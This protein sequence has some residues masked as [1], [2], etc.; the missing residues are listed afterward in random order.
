MTTN[1]KKNIA[2]ILASAFLVLAV[3]NGWPYSFFTILRLVVCASTAYVAW[4]A[5]EGKRTKW[6]WAFGLLAVLFNPFVPFYLDRDSWLV[7]DLLTALFLIISLFVFKFSTPKINTSQPEKKA[8]L[9]Y[10]EILQVS[11][12]AE[13]EVVEV[14]YR[15]LA[16]KYHPDVN[17]SD[18]ASLIM[19]ELNLAYQVLSDPQ[20]RQ[21]YDNELQFHEDTTKASSTSKT[22][23]RWKPRYLILIAVIVIVGFAGVVIVTNLYANQGRASYSP[24]PTPLPS[25]SQHQIQPQQKTRCDPD[26]SWEMPGEHFGLNK[27]EAVC[28]YRSAKDIVFVSGLIRNN[29]SESLTPVLTVTVL[30]LQGNPVTAS[31]EVQLQRMSS[32]EVRAINE[33]VK[34]TRAGLLLD[35]APSTHHALVSVKSLP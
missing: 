28:G 19:K 1:K 24:S 20:S 5:Y 2:I 23:N 7:I 25:S 9:N 18:E 3:F 33:Y 15:R 29:C 16:R 4:L 21:Q 6:T 17:E 32:K 27:I 11:P 14:A 10:Y 30:D 12:N 8:S 26:L 34:L 22:N 35:L 13:P 31:A